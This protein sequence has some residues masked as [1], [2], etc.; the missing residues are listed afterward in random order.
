[1]DVNFATKKLEKIFNSETNLQ[2]EYG[3]NAGKIMLRM[4]VLAHADNLSQV[5]AQ[6]PDRRHELTGKRKSTF[7]V[8]LKHPYRL[9]FK[10]NHEP[11]PSK[12]D[13]GIDL[14][15]VTAITIMGVEDY[16]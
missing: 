11:V 6:K 4:I 9:I 1:M 14:T 8:D 5:P 12:E 7:A 15:K 10:P 16:H 2:K 3:E 13:G